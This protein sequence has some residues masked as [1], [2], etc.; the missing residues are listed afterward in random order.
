MTLREAIEKF[1]ERYQNN[2]KIKELKERL[3]AIKAEA[4]N[5]DDAQ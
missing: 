5:E 1:R 2:P 3:L 4:K